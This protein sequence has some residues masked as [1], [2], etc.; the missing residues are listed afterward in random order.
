MAHIPTTEQI[1]VEWAKTVDGVDPTKVATTLP[2][3]AAVWASTGFVQV[4]AF[5]GSADVHVPMFA[6]VVRFGCWAANLNS[7]QPPWG[8]AGSIAQALMVATYS[9]THQDFD[10]G[11]EFHAARLLS[12]YPAGVPVR[13]PADEA[14][15]AHV[16]L[17]LV[18]GWTVTL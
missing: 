16:Y 14:V 4:T 12:V 15:F 13:V 9:H 8:R 18:L 3:D 17:D 2:A 11:A 1:A 7:A 5:P 6:P 10:L